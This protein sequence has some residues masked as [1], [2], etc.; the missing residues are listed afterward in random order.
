MDLTLPLTGGSLLL[1]ALTL[2]AYLLKLK[3]DRFDKHLEDCQTKSV[4]HARLEEKVIRIEG[5]LDDMKD[6]MTLRTERIDAMD[7]KLDN[8]AN[9]IIAKRNM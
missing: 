5:K 3:V 4:N 6:A 7:A 8:L 9:V 1:G 2:T